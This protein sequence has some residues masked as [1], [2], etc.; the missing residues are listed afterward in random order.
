MLW[1]AEA[2]SVGPDNF[3]SA[4]GRTCAIIQSEGLGGF[5]TVPVPMSVQRL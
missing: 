2:F 1:W 3:E 4:S 5:R